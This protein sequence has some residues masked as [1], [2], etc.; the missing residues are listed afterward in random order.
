MSGSRR[1]FSIDEAVRFG[2]FGAKLPPEE[3]GPAY[4][5]R[6]S[7][8][9]LNSRALQSVYDDPAYQDALIQQASCGRVDSEASRLRPIAWG[10][11][12]PFLAK[13]VCQSIADA[14]P[15]TV[16]PWMRG[17]R[18]R[19]ILRSMHIETSL[20]AVGVRHAH[21]FVAWTQGVLK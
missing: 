12:D 18:L 11:P 4:R 7:W 6:L 21:R 17:Q 14:M 5:A 9:S 2:E 8:R 20:E 3:L 15:A 13:M 16:V 10:K 1:L 19:R